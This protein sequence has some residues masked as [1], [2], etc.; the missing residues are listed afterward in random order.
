MCCTVAGEAEDGE[1][2]DAGLT[3]LGARGDVVALLLPIP[4]RAMAT[5][6]VQIATG[7]S[8]TLGGGLVGGSGGCRKVGP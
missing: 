8:S 6:T 1:V 5:L 3:P 4:E 2:V 7:C